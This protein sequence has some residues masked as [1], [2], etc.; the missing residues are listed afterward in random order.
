VAAAQRLERGRREEHVPARTNDAGHLMHGALLEVI[1]QAVQ[2][3]ERGHDVERRVGAGN[4]A[5]AAA[6]HARQPV[7][8]GKARPDRGDV[9]AEGPAV[10]PEQLEIGTGAAATVEEP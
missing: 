8:A 7:R 4:L 6:G 9:E 1:G 3:V 2:H 5:D 10:A